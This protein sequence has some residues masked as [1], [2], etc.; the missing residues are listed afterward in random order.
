[1]GD[2]PS[3]ATV[4]AVLGDAS[5][6]QFMRDLERYAPI[7]AK[8]LRREAQLAIKAGATRDDLADLLLRAMLVQFQKG[9]LDIRRARVDDY[10]AILAPLRSGLQTLSQQNSTWCEAAEIEHLLRLSP[11]DMITRMV[12][13]FSGDQ[14]AYHWVL[15]WGGR[16]LRAADTARRSP[17]Q[18]GAR[19]AVDKAVLQQYGLQLGAKEWGLALQVASFSRAEGQGYSEMRQVIESIDVCELGI[20]VVDLSDALPADNRARIWAELLPE[21]FYGNTPYVLAL[22]T[23]YFFIT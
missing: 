18:H 13:E 15:A 11:E 17:T 2:P 5:S 8:M 1:M 6:A 16:Y 12:S 9:A 3:I 10:D 14:E 7:D 19:T 4:E 22:V 20:T 21:I 23:D